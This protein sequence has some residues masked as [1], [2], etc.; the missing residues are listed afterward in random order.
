MVYCWSNDDRPALIDWDFKYS[1]EDRTM[2]TEIAEP[3]TSEDVGSL[4]E[5][6]GGGK[7]TKRGRVAAEDDPRKEF[8]FPDEVLEDGKIK[9]WSEGNGYIY[10]SDPSCHRPIKKDL[11]AAEEIY[12]DYRVGAKQHTISVLQDEVVEMKKSRD[13]FNSI[14]NIET[15]TKMKKVQKLRN[16]I[17]A[18]AKQCAE[19]GCNVEDFMGG[20]E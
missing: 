6:V 15:R 2:A 9:V 7:K 17:R 3:P 8:V 4:A 5:D 10:G 16:E 14:E 13:Q 19:Q 12:V 18:L 1:N 20:E 11:F